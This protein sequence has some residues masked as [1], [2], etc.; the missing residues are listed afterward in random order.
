VRAVN[1]SVRAALAAI[2]LAAAALVLTPAQTTAQTAQCTDE[3]GAHYFAGNQEEAGTL[4]VDK[5]EARINPLWSTFRPCSLDWGNDGVGAWVGIE[6]G[7]ASG[8]T[9]VLQLGIIRCNAI[10]A[11]WCWPN[12]P[13]GAGWVTVFWSAQGCQWPPTQERLLFMD[14]GDHKFSVARAWDGSQY[15]MELRVDD[16]LLRWLWMTDPKISCW[17]NGDTRGVWTGEVLDGGDSFADSS[18]RLNFTYVKYRVLWGTTVPVQWDPATNCS[19]LPQNADN[20]LHGCDR[21]GIGFG[22]AKVGFD[23]W[24]INRP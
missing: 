15:R 20:N 6:P 18:D 12:D 23:L 8:K 5:V 10:F 24:S 4:M 3:L 16:V 9:G 7:A 1:R 22:N 13:P 2:A 14:D 21:T 19:P 17:I 11:D